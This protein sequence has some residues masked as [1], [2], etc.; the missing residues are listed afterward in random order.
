MHFVGKWLLD[1]L[2]TFWRAIARAEELSDWFALAVCVFDFYDKSEI[3]ATRGKPPSSSQFDIQLHVIFFFSQSH[4]GVQELLLLNCK[5][6][7]KKRRKSIILLIAA[8][9]EI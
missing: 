1:G 5:Y 3:A 9:K 8:R 7:T 2:T 4:L 6:R